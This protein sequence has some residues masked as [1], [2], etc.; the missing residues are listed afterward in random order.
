MLKIKFIPEI[1]SGE[2]NLNKFIKKLVGFSMGPIVGALIS[3]ITVPI[4]TFFIS[5]TEFGKA[6]MFSV[7]QSLI[8]TFIYLGIDQSYTREYN[9]IKD[10]RE[11]FQNA[12]ILPLSASVLCSVFI[13]VFNEKFSML[14]FDTPKYGAISY[15]FSIMLIFSVVERFLLLAIR[16]EE[17]AVE[18]SFFSILVKVTILVVTIVLLYLGSKNFMTIIYATIF[19]QLLGD[20]FLIFKYRTLLNFSKFSL[21]KN[22]LK[23]MVIFG[24][25]L[26]VAASVSNLLNTSGRLFL[27]GFSSYYDLGVYNAALKIANLLQII[28]AAFTS[29]WVPTAYRWNK[30]KKSIK[31]FSF[32]SNALLFVVSVGFFCLLI[33][34]GLAISILSS[35]YSD[36][37]YV[38]G[39]LA[40]APILYTLSETSTLGI[41][42][43]GKSY[44][45]IYIS[46]LSVVPNLILNYI[47]VPYYGTI[48]A[49]IATAA[50]YIVFCLARTYFSKSNG[51]KINFSKQTVNMFIFFTAAIINSL[52][53]WWV[54]PA[55]LMLFVCSIV[56]QYTTL[57]E[58]SS[59][60]KYP[61]EWD[62]S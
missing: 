51:F 12:L 60:R 13:I 21:N 44:L 58:F 54:L 5:P 50:S 20:F 59:I 4:T 52:D 19:G 14:L 34:K 41:I 47:L 18:Y 17:K 38:I 11:V 61:N 8:V 32:I 27:R 36:A 57:K 16:M 30:E 37:Q 22:L 26:I 42:F 53:V 35:D 1:Y 10:K 48:G 2:I 31:H 3:F 23:R 9:Y 6:S 55:T 7:I 40:M 28:Q 29:F 43:S 15:L 33:F 46:I 56:S 45:N 62:F 39:L 49:G 24:L 25:P